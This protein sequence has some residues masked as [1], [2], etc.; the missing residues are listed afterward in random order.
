M[1][2]AIGYQMYDAATH[3]KATYIY[4]SRARQRTGQ[5]H[6]CQS[7]LTEQDISI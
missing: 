4:M 3:F 1:E 6:R 7:L 5:L 2:F